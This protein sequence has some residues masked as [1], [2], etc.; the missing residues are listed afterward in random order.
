MAFSNTFKELCSPSK[1]Y[2]GLSMF[3][4]F[5]MFLQNLGNS[6]SYH[7]G[8]YSCFVSSVFIVFL[9]KLLYILF[10]TWV[11]NL[12]CRDGHK[13]IAWFLFLF[14][15]ILSFVILGAFISM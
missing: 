12:I 14:P 4:L 13:G 5:V 9:F 8:C 3:L 7:L 6:H 11:L 1:M 10:W 2:F 15:I